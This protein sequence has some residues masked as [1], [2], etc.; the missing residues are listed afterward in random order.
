MLNNSYQDF[1]EQ[2][3]QAYYQ[4]LAGENDALA[5]RLPLSDKDQSMF[6]DPMIKSE[7]KQWKLVRSDLKESDFGKLENELNIK[8]P[9]IFKAFLGTYYHCF[10][11]PIGPNPISEPFKALK[12]AWNPYLVQCGYLPFAWDEDGYYIICCDLSYLP[13]ELSCPICQIDHEIL[14]DLTDEYEDEYEDEADSE[15][16]INKELRQNIAANMEQLAP[17]L[18]SYLKGFLQE[19]HIA[20]NNR[21]INKSGSSKN[22]AGSTS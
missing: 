17:D 11:N 5:L 12:R 4:K 10:D 21:L 8:L 15:F 20:T 16:E 22:V 2:F 18:C 13:D 19:K 9:E 3:F 7:W 1:M 14:F 6:L